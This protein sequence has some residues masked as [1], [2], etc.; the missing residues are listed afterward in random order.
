M[1][2]QKPI[3]FI[4]VPTSYFVFC[5]YLR[6]INLFTLRVSVKNRLIVMKLV[7]NNNNSNYNFFIAKTFLKKMN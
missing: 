4:V 6:F 1:T 5:R 2:S 3:R 7:T